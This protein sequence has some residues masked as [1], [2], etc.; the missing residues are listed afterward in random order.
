MLKI[1]TEKTSGAATAI[2]LRENSV[3]A[4]RR[5]KAL[6]ASTA[7]VSAQMVASGHAFGQDTESEADQPTDQIIVRGIA[8]QFRPDESDAATGLKMKL[9]DTPQSISVITPELL[10]TIGAINIYDATDLVPGVQKSGVGFGNEQISLRGIINVN[11]RINGL[12]NSL[13]ATSVEGYMVERVEIVRGPAS[14][15][16]GVTGSFGGEINSVLKRPRADGFTE[17]G[18]EFDHYGSQ[19]YK[20]DTTGE[21]PGTDGALRGRFTIRYDNL[22][23]PYDIENFN[24]EQETTTVLGSLAWDITPQTT[25]TVWYYHQE[26]NGDPVDGGSLV[27][28]PNGG[29]ALPQEVLPNFDADVWYFSNPNQSREELVLDHVLAEIEHTF[30]NDWVATASALVSQND[31]DVTMFYGTGL[32]RGGRALD[33]LAIYT[34]DTDRSSKELSFN[35][36]LGGDFELLGREHS[37]FAAFEYNDSLRP[38]VFESLNSVGVGVASVDLYADGVFDGVQPRFVDGTPF[39]PVFSPER[40]PAIQGTFGATT[41]STDFKGSFQLLLRPIDRVEVLAGLLVHDGDLRRAPLGGTPPDGKFREIV[42]RA[43]ITYDVIDDVGFVNDAKA[44]FSYTESF[45]PQ[46]VT[47]SDGVVR[48]LP[49]TMNAYEFGLKAELFEGAAGFSVAY[50][51]ND[52]ENINTAGSA[53]GNFADAQFPVAN[54][55]QKSRGVEVDLIGEV[56]PGWNVAFNYTW[57]D[58]EITDDT[59][60]PATGELQFPFFATPRSMPDHLGALTTT[61]EFLDGPLDGLRIG[62]TIKVSGDYAFNDALRRLPPFSPVGETPASLIDG[63]HTRLD[64]NVSYAGFTGALEG[65][66]LYAN[67]INVTD[68]DILVQKQGSP[69]FGITLIDRQLFKFG[70]TFSF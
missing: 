20:L 42:T 5:F 31:W 53:V 58:G 3:S 14:V 6:L 33:E 1:T 57:F 36:S 9:V 40:D 26:L 37:F 8:R 2:H 63:A 52:I 54:G 17:F 43:G 61:Y 39:V 46:I 23:L 34:Y 4:K 62:G 60:D 47:D 29:L 19:S 50:F 25:A 68:E 28:L 24:I 45:Q 27:T 38:N 15:V 41:E 11:Q 21:L 32:G 66:R 67:A 51:D 59:I 12:V 7:L 56:L 22:N 64:L 18:T 16:Y 44:Y 48:F 69:T 35:L 70:A 10:D 13:D 65:L 49:Q 55:T 30:G